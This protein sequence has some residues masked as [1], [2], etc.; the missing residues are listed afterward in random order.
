MRALLFGHV[1]ISLVGIA[2]GLVVA[3]GPIFVGIVQAFQKVPV[4]EALAPAQSE[5]P[6]VISQLAALALFVAVG[7][8]GVR[9][10]R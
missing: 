2:T 7:W 10:F 6:F 5:P 8:I 4:L 9:K 3:E 1:A